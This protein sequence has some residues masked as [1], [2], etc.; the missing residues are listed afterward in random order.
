MRVDISNVPFSRY[1]SYMGFNVVPPSWNLPGLILRTMYGVA[2]SREVFRVEPVRAG[3]VVPHTISATPT[4]LTM[5][6]D[7]GRV[8]VCFAEPDLVRVRMKGVGLRLTS[9]RPQGPY[10]FPAGE[11]RWQVNS[12]PN[13]TQ[14]MLTALRGSLKVDA[15]HLVQTQDARKKPPAVRGPLVVA[16]FVPDASGAA[17][18]AIQE[19]LTTPSRS[20]PDVSFEQCVR[21]VEA[22]WKAWLK[23]TPALPKRYAGAAELAMYINWSAVVGLSGNVRRPT[24][25]MSK[26]WMTQCWSWDHCFNAIA[27]SYRDPDLA[28]DQLMTLFDHQDAHGALPDSVSAPDLVWNFC[29]PPIH[30]WTLAKMAKA[31][32][33]LTPERLK[34]IYGPLCRWTEWWMQDRDSD[35]DGIPEYHHGN[36]SGWDNA[37]VYDGG[38]PAA[39]PD[40][41]A[42]LV[43]QMDVLSDLAKLLGRARDAARWKAR[44]GELAARMVERLWNGEQFV[45]RR[46]FSGAVFA[47]G[48]CL[49]NHMAIAAG[50]RLPKAVREKVAAALAPDG[51]FVT[52]YGPATE[53]PRSPLYVP[54]GY[55]RG[56]IW[57]SETVLIVDG[58]ARAGFKQQ[59][60]EIARRYCEM[61][62]KSGFAE[63]YNADTGQPLRDKAYT[64]GSSAYIILAREFLRG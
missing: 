19:F 28:W 11:G 10:A 5:D 56:P 51:R 17:E 9:L 61:C 39:S 23:T 60:R 34:E 4:L 63:N 54:D 32:G 57:G 44:A 48:D 58:L 26:N 14:Y 59:A 41:P 6:A 16:D 36:D 40:L 64:W 43:V 33:L 29:K 49:L 46:A 27:L 7:G 18:A 21:G 62:L 25:L 47:E 45:T 35:G 1:G 30:G 20:V 3:E 15:P 55:W 53:N 12:F 13:R 31:R 22:E 37:T 24:M 50:K 8:E 52:R 2:A 38:F 42:F